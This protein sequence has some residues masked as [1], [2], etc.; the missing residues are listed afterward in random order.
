[1]VKI[2]VNSYFKLLD[3]KLENGTIIV[4]IIAILVILV[5]IMVNNNYQNNN[6][7][8]TKIQLNGKTYQLINE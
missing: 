4:I 3:E 7:E 6:G 5:S 2:I 1:M 8:N